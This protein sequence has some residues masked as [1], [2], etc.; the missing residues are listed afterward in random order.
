MRDMKAI[1]MFPGFQD[2][3]SSITAVYH[4]MVKEENIIPERPGKKR[5]GLFQYFNL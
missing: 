2:E 3:L 4:D 5:K 1:S